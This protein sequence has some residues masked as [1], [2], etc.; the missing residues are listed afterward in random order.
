MHCR[1]AV[2]ARIEGFISDCFA[3]VA[4]GQLP[5]LE[6]VSR[7]EGNTHMVQDAPAA[8][9]GG[10]HPAVRA[11]DDADGGGGSSQHLASE[12]AAAGG[13]RAGSGGGGNQSRR[14]RLGARVQTKSLV[15]N[16]GK[17]AYTI[18]RGAGCCQAN[19]AGIAGAPR[20]HG[21]A[22]AWCTAAQCQCGPALLKPGRLLGPSQARA[23]SGAGAP[24][25]R[26]ARRGPHPEAAALSEEGSPSLLRPQC[27]RCWRRRT[28]CC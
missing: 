3:A 8:A 9:S 5:E 22:H 25:I 26:I 19:D 18:A 20:H 4:A 13:A 28:R 17:Q 10:P 27:S 12:S 11:D 24:A 14:L 2:I 6:L 21:H 15:R 23:S 16:Q 7:A 1:T